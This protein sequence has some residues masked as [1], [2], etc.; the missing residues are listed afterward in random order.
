MH[1]SAQE[2]YSRY[3]A[4]EIQFRILNLMNS[5]TWQTATS[6]CV[7]SSLL[8]LPWACWSDYEYAKS[9]QDDEILP[10]AVLIRCQCY[11]E[12]HCVNLHGNLVQSF[13]V[14][15]YK[16]IYLMLCGSKIHFLQTLLLL[17]YQINTSSNHPQRCEGRELVQDFIWTAQACSHN[18]TCL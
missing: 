9:K 2:R 6:S 3:T 15:S 8:W 17:T 7:S 5:N 10:L 16:V 12:K 4:P 18:E 13:C 11:I 14:P 1:L